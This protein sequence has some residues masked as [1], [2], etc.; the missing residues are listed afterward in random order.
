MKRLITCILLIPLIAAFLYKP[1]IIGFYE[2]NK[3]FVI[4]HLCVNKDKPEMHCDGKCFLEQQTSDDEAKANEI[5]LSIIKS[6]KDDPFLHNG[7]Y[8]ELP[9]I[10]FSISMIFCEP[11]QHVSLGYSGRIFQPPKQLLS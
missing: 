5:V 4:E 9:V 10:P 6:I 2:C 1:L 3:S 11:Q 7:Q 8:Q